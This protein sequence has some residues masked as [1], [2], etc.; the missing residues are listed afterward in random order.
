GF[1]MLDLHMFN[2]NAPFLTFNVRKQGFIYNYT[3]SYLLTKMTIKSTVE[4]SGEISKDELNELKK[5]GS[6]WVQAD[7]NSKITHREW[8][9]YKNKMMAKYNV[10]SN[11]YFLD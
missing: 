6:E 11:E 5:P 4:T 3:N 7:F 9:L 1:G 8:L 2:I 10:D